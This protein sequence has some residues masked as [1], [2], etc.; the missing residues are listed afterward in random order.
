MV[1]HAAA[2]ERID[3]AWRLYELHHASNG[4]GCDDTTFNIKIAGYGG[5]RHTAVS[6]YHHQLCRVDDKVWAEVLLNY[7]KYVRVCAQIPHPIRLPRKQLVD[8]HSAE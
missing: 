7:V 3:G 1:R 2:A 8:V 5:V 4:C 6:T